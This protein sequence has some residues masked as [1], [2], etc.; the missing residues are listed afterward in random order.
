[1]NAGIKLASVF[2]TRRTYQC[3][4]CDYGSAL[5]FSIR[6]H[7]MTRHLNYRPYS[8]TFCDF[9]AISAYIVNK[10]VRLRHP[11]V[12]DD[13]WNCVYSRTEEMDGRLKDG[14]FAVNVTKDVPL[15][16]QDHTYTCS[17][18]SSVADTERA[19]SDSSHSR[20]R[21][22][23]DN[24]TP[25]VSTFP[26]KKKKMMMMMKKKKPG[27]VLGNVCFYRCR[28]CTYMATSRK[29]MNMHIT[30]RH[31]KLDL[32]K[33]HEDLLFTCHQISG[34]ANVDT[35]AAGTNT[36]VNDCLHT[37]PDLDDIPPSVSE[38]DVLPAE[39]G[40]SN[41]ASMCENSYAVPCEMENDV[42]YCCETCPC[43][44]S[45][46]EALSSHKCAASM[47]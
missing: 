31:G 26:W 10:H 32:G 43:S 13:Q 44:F 21:V 34:D 35:P 29:A 23:A 28:Q 38:T 9:A 5:L 14:Y 33:N 11:D 4:Y 25:K 46:L 8:C 3:R 16:L 39:A 15:R 30:K 19:T 17:A 2:P 27:V 7:V 37:L 45:T 47:Q 42:I 22:R 40:A 24:G 36:M 12:P 6:G 18:V 41:P 1:M 20:G